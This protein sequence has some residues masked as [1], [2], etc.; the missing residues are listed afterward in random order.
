MEGSLPL[1]IVAVFPFVFV[2]FWVGVLK[3]L[4][5]L[6]WA[7]LVAENSSPSEPPR[8]AQKL[9]GQT[10]RI[11]TALLPINYSYCLNAWIDGTGLWLRPSLLWR[12]FHPLLMIRWGDIEAVEPRRALMLK[13]ARLT[14]KSRSRPLIIYGEL[15]KA[16]EQAWLKRQPAAQ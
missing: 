1:I 9:N 12:P 15:G 14:L 13:R 5:S 7:R 3:L 4:S 6:G 8:N 10:M 16:V 11:E 2:A